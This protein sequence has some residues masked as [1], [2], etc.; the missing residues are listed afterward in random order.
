[1]IEN[2][3]TCLNKSAS[4]AANL[5]KQADPSSNIGHYRVNTSFHEIWQELVK[6]FLKNSLL[7]F[8][9]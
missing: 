2:R 8:S 6:C 9:V 5:F 7:R 3:H 1:M 4:S